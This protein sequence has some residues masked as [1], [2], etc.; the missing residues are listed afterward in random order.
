[1]KPR[2]VLTAAEVALAEA[3]WR[4][5]GTLDGLCSALAISRDGLIERRR[6]GDQ[7][8]HLER[9]QAGCRRSGP[10]LAPP[11]P[12]EIAARAA[13][14][15]ATWTETEKLN[16]RAGPGSPVGSWV[17][18]RPGGRRASTRVNRRTW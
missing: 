1:M 7:L 5:G 17:G 9:R 8:S 16:R 13:E 6:P 14:I 11:S 18:E 10:R 4:D 12:A 15:R 3:I 2:R